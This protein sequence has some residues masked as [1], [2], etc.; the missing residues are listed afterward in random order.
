MLIS[1]SFP[2][3]ADS[4][5]RAPGSAAVGD[6]PLR[7]YL[8]RREELAAGV[9]HA[10]LLMIHAVLVVGLGR[11]LDHLC[12]VPAGAVRPWARPAVWVGTAAL[13]LS[14]GRRLYYKWMELRQIRREMVALRAAFRLAGD[15]GGPQGEDG[16]RHS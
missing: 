10:L 13:V 3:K 8:R 7:R 9:A 6:F 15:E 14:V 1:K 11:S 2:E 4:P 12:R 5:G 16:R